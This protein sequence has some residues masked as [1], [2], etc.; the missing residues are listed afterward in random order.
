MNS[1]GQ[2]FLQEDLNRDKRTGGRK[3][4]DRSTWQIR[5]RVVL[6]SLSICVFICWPSVRIFLLQRLSLRCCFLLSALILHPI[7]RT[8]KRINFIFYTTCL[9]RKKLPNLLPCSNGANK[10]WL[11]ITMLHICVCISISQGLTQISSKK[12]K[13]LPLLRERCKIHLNTL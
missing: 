5:D 13:S 9:Q 8:D 10:T 1:Y 7:A 2:L 11:T 6:F 4:K 3:D 12:Q